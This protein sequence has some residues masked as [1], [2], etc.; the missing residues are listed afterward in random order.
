MKD[1]LIG[2]C[3]FMFGNFIYQWVQADPNMLVAAERTFFQAAIVLFVW[4]K[5]RNKIG[6]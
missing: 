4:F 5:L 3:F 1:T 2:C 6:V